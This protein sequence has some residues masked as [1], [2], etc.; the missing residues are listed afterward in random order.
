MELPKLFDGQM[1][2]DENDPMV[3][4]MMFIGAK[5]KVM[6]EMLAEK[7]EDT[8]KAYNIRYIIFYKQSVKI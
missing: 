3:Q 6:I 5:S 7:N 4:W 8:G 1:A 2:I